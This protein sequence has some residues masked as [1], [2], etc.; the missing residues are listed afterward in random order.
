MRRLVKKELMKS[1]RLIGQWV[2]Q[3]YRGEL[4][5][6]QEF[7]LK[8]P[9]LPNLKQPFLSCSAPI[10]S[11]VSPPLSQ[12]NITTLSIVEEPKELP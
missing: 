10:K 12:A 2:Q 4:S 11:I 5:F 1:F 8:Q 6:A 7:D 3:L 9:N